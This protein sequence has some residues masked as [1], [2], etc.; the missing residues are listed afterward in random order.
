MRSNR[1][2]RRARDADAVDTALTEM[3]G[4]L[5]DALN[6]D[7][8]VQRLESNR[9]KGVWSRLARLERQQHDDRLRDQLRHILAEYNDLAPNWVRDP[10]P[11]KQWGDTWGRGDLL[12]VKI[13]D[14]QQRI[15]ELRR[16]R[17]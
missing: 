6:T 7:E 11:I 16:D 12:L 10:V 17:P 14:A 9:S 2:A 15:D 8:G 1:R 4:L 3:Y 5:A 13:G